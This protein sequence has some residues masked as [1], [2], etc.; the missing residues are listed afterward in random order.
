MSNISEALSKKGNGE[1]F[2]EQCCGSGMG[3]KLGSGFRDEQPGSY[4]REPGNNFFGL[5]YLNSLKR[6]RNGKNSDPGL[7]QFGSGM[8]KNRIRDEH[9]GAA[10]L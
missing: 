7:K 6:I 3:K 10:T 4:F 5:I 2:F 8:G 9:P 1:G